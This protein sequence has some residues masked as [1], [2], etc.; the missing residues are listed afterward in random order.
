VK[1]VI[2]GYLLRS[3]STTLS[4]TWEIV[5]KKVVTRTLAK[6]PPQFALIKM[7]P[8]GKSFILDDRRFFK[9]K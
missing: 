5:K 1:E 3:E 8:D 7:D 2:G 4:D 6:K 9:I